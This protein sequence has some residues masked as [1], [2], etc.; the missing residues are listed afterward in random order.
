MAIL[1]EASE[2]LSNDIY[3]EYELMKLC[4]EECEIHHMKIIVEH[5]YQMIGGLDVLTEG[6]SDILNSITSFLRKMKDAIINF[7]KNIYNRFKVLKGDFKAVES[8]ILDCDDEIIVQGYDFTITE[9]LPNLEYLRGAVDEYNDLLSQASTKTR[10]EIKNRETEFLSTNNQSKL[11]GQLLNMTTEIDADSFDTEVRKIF[12]NGD[13]ETSDIVVK[14]SELK[15]HLERYNRMDND[16][17][18]AKKTE[19]DLIVLIDK[20]I[21]FFDTKVRVLQDHSDKYMKTSKVSID[22]NKFESKANDSMKH[23]ESSQLYVNALLSYMS[24]KVNKIGSLTTK[25]A[26]ERTKALLDNQ[27]QTKKILQKAYS[28]GLGKK[29]GDDK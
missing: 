27:V 8:V 19:T 13:E 28:A 29:K 7:F 21:K 20:C 12:R 23:S 4:T 1:I 5:N 2:Y 17:K 26:T 3:P 24:T 14:A 6:F 25:V 18:R 10:T 15:T 22:N 9:D 16:I 11:R